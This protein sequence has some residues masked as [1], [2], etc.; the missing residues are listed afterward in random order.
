[1]HAKAYF[2]L[3]RK[4]ISRESSCGVVAS[5]LKYDLVRRMFEGWYAIKK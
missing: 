4:S 2:Y 5:V 1:M 3:I